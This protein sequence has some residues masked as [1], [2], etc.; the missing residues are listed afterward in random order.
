MGYDAAAFVERAGYGAASD[1]AGDA[2]GEAAACRRL[3]AAV[4]L[5]NMNLIFAPVRSSTELDRDRAFRWIGSRDFHIVCDLDGVHAA[6]VEAVI[7]RRL[8][9]AAWAGLGSWAGQG[10]DGGADG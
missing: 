10:G 3:F 5:E 4:L 9:V 6:S 7:R 1:F 8:E 2:D